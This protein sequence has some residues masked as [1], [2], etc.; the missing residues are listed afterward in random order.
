MEPWASTE[1]P[2]RPACPVRVAVEEGD[3]PAER[4]GWRGE[5]SEQTESRPFTMLVLPP[6]GTGGASMHQRVLLSL[7]TRLPVRLHRN[8]AHDNTQ[9]ALLSLHFETETRQ[10]KRSF[11]KKESRE[12]LMRASVPY[13]PTTVPLLRYTILVA[14]SRHLFHNV[15]PWY[16]TTRHLFPTVSQEL[17]SPSCEPSS[18]G[19]PEAKP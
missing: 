15:S 7:C 10:H 14:T 8:Q 19:S 11:A 12:S 2:S 1:M 5:G 17:A 16:T 18:D 13:S 4:I 3:I 9:S 6:G